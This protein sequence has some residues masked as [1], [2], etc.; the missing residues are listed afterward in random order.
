MG[1]RNPAMSVVALC[2]V[3]LIRG[4]RSQLDLTKSFCLCNYQLPEGTPRTSQSGSSDTRF[5]A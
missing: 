3:Q 2:I 4:R 5:A 1:K